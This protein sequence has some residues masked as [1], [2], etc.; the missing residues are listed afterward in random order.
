MK[1]NRQ[2]RY[3]VGVLVFVWSLGLIL[4]QA[5]AVHIGCG[6]VLGP[7]GT[8]VLDSVVGPCGGPGPALTLISATLDLAG[9][10]VSCSAPS[11]YGI[12]V[13]GKKSKVRN[14]TVSGCA[15]GVVLLDQGSHE[16]RG[17]T[18]SGNSTG[19]TIGS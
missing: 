4:P 14:G 19:F 10:T 12:D 17:V 3:S 7:G 16:V 15:N 2:W 5:Q 9:H 11:N 18:A 8:F 13:E 1:Y 6:A